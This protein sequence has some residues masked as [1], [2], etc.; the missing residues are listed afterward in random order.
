MKK[1]LI[2]RLILLLFPLTISC[3]QNNGNSQINPDELKAIL[4]KSEKVYSEFCSGCHG[5]S[6]KSL[7]ESDF[8][9]G[10]TPEAIFASIYDGRNDGEMPSF[11]DAFGDT[12]I[13]E[14]VVS[15]LHE[16]KDLNLYEITTQRE[17]SEIYKSK[18]LSYK[19]ETVADNFDSPWGMVF[20]QGGDLLVTEKAGKLYKVNKFGN[21]TE[22]KGVPKVKY[23][24]QGGLL[25]I[26]LHP[27][28]A[29]NNLIYLS[30]SKENTEDDDLST[31]AVSM[32]T[33]EG[34]ELKN[35]KV[36]FTALPYENN[37]RHFGS[38]LEFD[39]NVYLII[40]IGDR[41]KRDDYPQDISTYPGKVHR[42]YDDGRI[43]EDNPFVNEPN[44]VVSIFSYGHRNQQGMIKHPETDEIWTHEH[45]P[46]GGDEINIVK[47]GLNYCWPVISFGVN[48]SGTSF[49]DLTTKKGMEQPLHQRTPSIA[50]SGMEFIS[51]DI[52]PEWKGRLLV[53]SLSFEFLGMYG[54]ENQKVVYE[55][56]LLIDIG[57]VRNVKQ[58][59]D[60][61]IY[62]ALENPGIIYRIIPVRD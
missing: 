4:E 30:Y 18:D 1:N 26:E 58:G 54:I 55:D 29:E 22:I 16:S 62:V 34:N 60:G 2:V 50:P 27:K 46:K 41:G 38:R 49:T 24:S 31:T 56:R 12:E 44:A 21:R 45:G 33:L 57:R 61:Y 28:F 9:H 7:A 52:Y 20:L 42:F 43:P 51:S 17:V 13:R 37:G 40:T 15:I 8:V 47:K 11:K 48:Y 3:E 23:K 32:L 6:I 5:D 39:I 25:D 10:K 59:L 53:G 19:L 35:E 14:M 36:I